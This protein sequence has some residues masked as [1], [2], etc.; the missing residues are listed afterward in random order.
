MANR[1]R[2]L[3]LMTATRTIVRRL[4]LGQYRQDPPGA[5]EVTVGHH[6][7]LALAETTADG[8][9]VEV[10]AAVIVANHHPLLPLSGIVG[11]ATRSR[12][13]HL[14]RVR[15]LRHGERAHGTGNVP[16]ITT[17]EEMIRGTHKS[18]GSPALMEMSI[19]K[20]YNIIYFTC[21]RRVLLSSMSLPA[22]LPRHYLC[23][24]QPGKSSVT[25]CP[26]IA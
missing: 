15:V 18:Q 3:T 16:V 21:P 7:R 24:Q 23:S 9:K 2:Q 12:R 1:I 20:K 17:T 19:R 8:T 11:A 14:V 5:D 26:V 13:R 4:P 22:R 6:R 10:D 25:R